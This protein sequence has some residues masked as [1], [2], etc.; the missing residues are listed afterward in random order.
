[1]ALCLCSSVIVHGA[2]P[3]GG[4]TL[5]LTPQGQ[6]DQGEG[7]TVE[8]YELRETDPIL[9]HFHSLGMAAH[10]S[11]KKAGYAFGPLVGI[12]H[13]DRD[14]EFGEGPERRSWFP[15]VLILSVIED[16]MEVGV[17]EVEVEYEVVLDFDPKTFASPGLAMLEARKLRTD[18]TAEIVLDLPPPETMN[19]LERNRGGITMMFGVIIASAVV[20]FLRRGVELLR[21]NKNTPENSEGAAANASATPDSN[22]KSKPRTRSSSAK[23]K[24]KGG[25]VKKD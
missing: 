19:F 17:P 14:K 6:V 7:V 9:S 24:K 15:M 1:M 10:R 4:G 12:K 3:G 11:L 5:R 22:D 18:G 8:D 2:R 21:K 23:G 20:K 25:G 16:A 13:S